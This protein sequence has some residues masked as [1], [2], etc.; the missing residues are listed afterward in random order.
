MT[1]KG[2]LKVAGG[3]FLAVAVL[4]ATR[5]V[6]HWEILIA[7]WLVPLW[8]SGVGL[9]VAGWLALTAFKLGGK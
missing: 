4:H 5:L 7:G 9:V 8:V 3:I 2:F 6:F 1:Q